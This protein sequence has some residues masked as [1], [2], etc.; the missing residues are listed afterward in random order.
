MKVNGLRVAKG[1]YEGGNPAT[2]L[3]IVL[4][5]MAT[6]SFGSCCI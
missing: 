6:G 4:G 2:Y 1:K 3:A 5:P